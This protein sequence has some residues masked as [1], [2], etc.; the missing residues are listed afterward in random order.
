[1]K[2]LTVFFVLALLLSVSMVDCS[3]KGGEEP[4]D[5]ADTTGL[6]QIKYIDTLPAGTPFKHPGTLHTDD[7]FNRI[8]AALAGNLEPWVS[9]YNK[10]AANSHAKATYNPNPVETL[11]RG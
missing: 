9:G 3:K 2:Q 10:L 1:M 11:I 6:V 5:L 4:D 8:K 7:D